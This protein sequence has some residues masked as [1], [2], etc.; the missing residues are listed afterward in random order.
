M[1]DTSLTY[2]ELVRDYFS[3]AYGENWQKFYDYLVELSKVFDFEF[4]E[5]EKSL[6]YSISR[7]Y[8]PPHAE[9]LRRVRDVTAEGLKLIRGNY[10]SKYRTTTFHVR[11]LEMHTEYCNLISDALMFKANGMDK[12]AW[13]KFN[14]FCNTMGKYEAEFQTV[15]DHGLAMNSLKN[16]VFSLKTNRPEAVYM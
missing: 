12:S 5:Q 9:Q 4:V 16:N 10:N 6:D 2:D 8:N 3:I 14:L 13:E 1:Y 7:F 11:L 15:Y